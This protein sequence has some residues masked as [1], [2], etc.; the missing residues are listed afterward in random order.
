[1]FFTLTLFPGSSASLQTPKYSEC[2]PSPLK[3]SVQRLLP[4][5]N[6]L[7]HSPCFFPPCYLR[8]S[9]LSPNLFLSK[10]FLQSHCP[11]IVCVCA[12]VRSCVRSCVRACVR[13][14]IWIFVVKLCTIKDFVIAERQCVLVAVSTFCYYYLLLLCI[15]PQGVAPSGPA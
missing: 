6:H 15:L 4:R 2:H 3:S 11:E 8:L 14:R 5:S 12:C 1:M 9:N 13:A 7:E 10:T